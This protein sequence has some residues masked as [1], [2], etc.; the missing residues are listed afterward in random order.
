M[1]VIY[2]KTKNIK[3]PV[4]NALALFMYQYHRS[5]TNFTDTMIMKSK[6]ISSFSFQPDSMDKACPDGDRPMRL[7]KMHV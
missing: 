5:I 7:I 2:K 4:K 1:S 3:D 6:N